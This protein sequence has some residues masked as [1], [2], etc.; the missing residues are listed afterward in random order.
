MKFNLSMKKTTTKLLALA[1]VLVMAMMA[2][3]ACGSSCSSGE[4]Q[5]DRLI[6]R[7]DRI[8]VW[9]KSIEEKNSCSTMDRR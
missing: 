4:D 3:A 8:P 7:G 5:G 9:R 2:L 1:L 6:R